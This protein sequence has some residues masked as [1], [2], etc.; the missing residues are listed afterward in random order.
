MPTIPEVNKGS[1]DSSYRPEPKF[2]VLSKMP[3]EQT[4]L[5]PQGRQTVDLRPTIDGKPVY[6]TIIPDT[7][8]FTYVLRNPD[9]SFT[10]LQSG[11]SLPAHGAQM[12]TLETD[13]VAFMKVI[14]ERTGNEIRRRIV[15]DDV[16]SVPEKAEQEGKP[17]RLT[18]RHED[19]AEN[20]PYILEILQMKPG[21]NNQLVV[22]EKRTVTSPDGLLPSLPEEQ[23]ALAPGDY[24]FRVVPVRQ[25]YNQPSLVTVRGTTETASSRQL[26]AC[27]VLVRVGSGQEVSVTVEQHVKPYNVTLG[28][29]TARDELSKVRAMLIFPR[30]YPN[31]GDYDIATAKSKETI[32]QKS[33]LLRIAAEGEEAFLRSFVDFILESSLSPGRCNI[34]EWRRSIILYVRPDAQGNLP[35]AFRGCTAEEAIVMTDE[36][37]EF[38]KGMQRPRLLEFVTELFRENM[39][40][41]YR[42]EDAMG[43]EAQAQEDLQLPNNEP[44]PG[45]ITK[46]DAMVRYVPGYLERLRKNDKEETKK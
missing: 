5:L 41:P 45:H 23:S 8:Y 9:G 21:A 20:F 24:L 27:P 37:R 16:L 14:E 2:P 29:Y 44:S 31:M 10:R 19:H 36:E 15:R 11:I 39:E 46:R 17:A 26:D 12:L 18:L 34:C 4:I 42:V 30:G 1:E 6:A 38:M 43:L 7:G 28:E 35:D 13:P 33:D 32:E 3:L 25:H 22:A 40:Q